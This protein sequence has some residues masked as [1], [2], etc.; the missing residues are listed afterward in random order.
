MDK[1]VRNLTQELRDVTEKLKILTESTVDDSATVKIITIVSA[2]YLPGSFVAVSHRS[3]VIR[4]YLTILERLWN[5]F[6]CLRWTIEKYR[7]WERLLDFYRNMAPLDNDYCCDL[8][9]GC[10]E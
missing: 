3:I 10:L 7:D 2:F 9:L 8:C 6:L 5:E 4:W 1:E